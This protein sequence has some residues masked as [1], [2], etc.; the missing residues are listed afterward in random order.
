MN[1]QRV[2]VAALAAI[3]LVLVA[4]IYRDIFVPARP[5]GSSLNLASVSRRSVTASVTGTGSLVP[6]AQANVNFR[7][8]GTLTEIDVHVGDHV[9]AGQ[10]LARVDSTTEGQALAAAQANLQV[11]Q[12]NLQAVETP[13]TSSQIAQL[14]HSL[15][16]AQQTYNDTVAQV[17]LTNTQDAN[18]VTADKNQLAIDQQ[19]L[20][21]SLTYQEDLQSLAA[22]KATLQTAVA[23]FN[24]DGCQPYSYPFTSP[25]A[26]AA[27][28]GDFTTVS[29]DQTA[30]NTAQGKV[31]LDE[32]T[33]SA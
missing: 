18:Q 30:V 8:S 21:N 9:V 17:N 15:A 10:T 31:T 4:L 12:A 24:A 29:S 19:V 26:P 25:P 13:L 5:A 28:L 3:A 16:I 14:Q 22:A 11:A 7:V 2:V 32:A 20:D 23:T 33:V 27:C 1:R 6:M